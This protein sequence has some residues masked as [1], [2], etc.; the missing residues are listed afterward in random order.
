MSEVNEG[1]RELW[2]SSQIFTKNPA[3][4]PHALQTSESEKDEF[5]ARTLAEAEG[6][7]VL[8]AVR[9]SGPGLDPKGID[10]GLPVLHQGH[11]G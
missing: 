9:D 3:R 8:I 2:V 10:G 4:G 11:C 7:H 6:T 5:D 1:P